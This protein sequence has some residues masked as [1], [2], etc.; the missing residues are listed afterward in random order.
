MPSQN[1]SLWQ[2]DYFKM[3]AI[4]TPQIQGEFLTSPLTDENNLDREPVPGRKLLPE[5]TFLYQKGIC[6]A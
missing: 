5:I 1:V 3:K 2:G 6:I 4:K